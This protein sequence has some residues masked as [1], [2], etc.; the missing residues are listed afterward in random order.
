MALQ[1]YFL[2]FNNTIRLDFE[3]NSTLKE[4]REILV[5]KLRDSGELPAFEE[6]NQGSY[7]LHTGIKPISGR[8][9]D[10]DVGLRFNV[11]YT[12]YKPFELKNIIKDILK[13]HTEYGADIKKPCVTVT[14]SKE[15]EASYHV[16]LVVYSYE[17]KEN[18]NFQMYIA[19]G[20]ND[21]NSVWEKADPIKLVDYIN[22]T[23]EGGEKRDQFRRLVRY[24]KRW[25]NLKF[26]DSGHAEPVSI[27]ITL[28]VLEYFIFYSDNDLD[29]L[30]NVVDRI[31]ERF[32]MV[33]LDENNR[34]LYKIDCNLPNHLNFEGDTN[35]FC[36]MTEIQM[37]DFRDKVIKLKEDLQKVKYEADEYEQC[38]LLN[39]IF[40]D[41][42]KIP[43]NQEVSKKQT[44]F[45]PY[46]SSSGVIL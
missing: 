45:I 39:K 23:I 21:N 7:Q 12:E 43:E 38:K 44:N 37:T 29:S 16:D 13:N 27:G 6:F 40:G 5:K 26:A 28:M 10:I 18:K 33:S 41:D 11:N 22:N 9:F 8:E 19:K 20:K 31:K 14:Y 34:I 17:D 35:V 25:K 24:L 4:K 3:T 46:S 36:K 32:Y 2:D 1:K 42:F 15:G 30:I